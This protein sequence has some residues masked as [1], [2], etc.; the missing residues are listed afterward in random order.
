M[1]DFWQT[2]GDGNYDNAGFRMRGHQFTDAEGRYRLET[3]IPGEYP[4]RT[5]HIH[6]KVFGPDGRELITTQIYLVGISD[7]VADSI[8][9]PALLAQDLEPDA[10]GRRRVAFD[11]IVQR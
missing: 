5:P 7:Q 8:Y 10:D 11:F 1:V 4:G 6:V 3:V 2:D 9:D